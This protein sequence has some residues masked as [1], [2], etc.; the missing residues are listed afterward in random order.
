MQYTLLKEELKDFLVF[1]ANDI[2][3]VDSDFHRQRFSEW[4]K[5]GYI[6]KIAKEYYIFSDTEI[7]EPVLFIIANAIYPHSY[8]SLEMALSYYHLIPESVY[9]ITSVTSQT[10]RSYATPAGNFTYR[11]IKP[12]LMFGYRLVEYQK[13]NFKMAEIE[14]AILDYFYINPKLANENEFAELRFNADSFQSQVNMKKLTDYLAQFKNKALEK[15]INKFI[16]FISH[17]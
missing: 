14:K 2:F 8:I 1:S 16:S 3:K 12:E 15:R 6:K 7:N 9:S 17:A 11:K 5:K 10:T 4:Q 13:H